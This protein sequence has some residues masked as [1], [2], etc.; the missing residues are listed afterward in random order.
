M[1]QAINIVRFFVQVGI[2]V[3]VNARFFGVAPSEAFV[4]YLQ[5]SGSPFTIVHGAYESLEI[6]ITHTVFPFIAIAVILGTGLIAGRALCAW[7]CPMGLLQDIMTII[8]IKRVRFSGAT[9]RELKDIKYVIAGVSLLWSIYIASKRYASAQLSA[10]YHFA[11]EYPHWQT[12]DSPFSIFSPAATLFAYIPW[13]VMWNPKV[14]LTGG[15]IGWVKIILAVACLVASV[16]VPRFFCRY[17]CPLAVCFEPFAKCK[18]VRIARSK[19]ATLEEFNRVMNEVCPMGVEQ[20]TKELKGVD[21][22]YITSPSCI[23]CGRCVSASPHFT[24]K[25]VF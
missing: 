18:V 12:S 14:L 13:M 11:D 16:F 23:H 17:L 3:F 15:I 2:L 24:Q 6:A 21:A 20:S 7:A 10:Q 1:F 4:P 25:L 5:P 9:S 8:P 22:E 19:N